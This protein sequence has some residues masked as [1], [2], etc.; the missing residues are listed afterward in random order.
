M[1]MTTVDEETGGVDGPAVVDAA[2]R[3]VASQPGGAER[4]LL[5]HGRR[6]DGTCAGCLTSPVTWPCVVGVIATRALELDRR[7]AGRPVA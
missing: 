2:I 7:A 3:F 6:H 5:E 1:T 4:I